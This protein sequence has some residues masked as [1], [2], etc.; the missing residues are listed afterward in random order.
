VDASVLWIEAGAMSGGSRNQVE[1]AHDLAEFFGPAVKSQ[2]IVT[3]QSPQ[4]TFDGCT[5]SPKTTTFGVDIWRLSLPTTAKSGLVYA[6][7]VIRFEKTKSPTFFRVRVAA[8]GS[9][10]VSEWEAASTAGGQIGTTSGGR[11]FGVS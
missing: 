11:R 2:Q 5:F 1:F 8:P 4:K 7:N 10:Q 9:Q 6:D 3:V